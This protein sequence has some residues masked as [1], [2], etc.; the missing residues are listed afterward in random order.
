[1]SIGV[2]AGDNPKPAHGSGDYPKLPDIGEA[3][4]GALLRLRLTGFLCQ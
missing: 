4:L 2:G 3:K 1:M